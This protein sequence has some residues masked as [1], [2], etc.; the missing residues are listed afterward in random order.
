MQ[1]RMRASNVSAPSPTTP[2]RLSLRIG[3]RTGPTCGAQWSVHD[4]GDQD[5]DPDSGEERAGTFDFEEVSHGDDYCLDN[6][7]E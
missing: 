6:D 4:V 5:Y 2:A 7:Q 1:K 3:R